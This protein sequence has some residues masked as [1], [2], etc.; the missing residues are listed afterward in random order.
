MRWVPF[1][2]MAVLAALVI[3]VPLVR[4]RKP[5]VSRADYDLQVYRDQ[6]R[7]LQEDVERGVVTKEQKAAAR[8]EID[9][10]ILGVTDTPYRRTGELLKWQMAVAL[11]ILVPAVSIGLYWVLGA[12]GA[13][14]QP[15]AD[16]APIIQEAPIS[17]EVLDFIAEQTAMLEINPEDGEGWMLLGRAH[18]Y[19]GDF[20]D[21]V[22]AFRRAIALGLNAAGTQMEMVESLYNIAGGFITQEAQAAIDAALV[23]D[24]AHPGARFYQGLALSQAER[25]QEAFDVWISLAADTPADAPLW[26][27][28][29]QSLQEAAQQLGLNLAELMPP[30]PEAAPQSPLEAMTAEEQMALIEGMVS[31][32][33]ER[34]VEEPDDLEGWLRLSQSY[35]VLGLLDDAQEAVARAVA[36]S[37]NDP[38]VLLQQ[39][40]LMLTASEDGMVPP[41]AA[42]IFRRALELEPDSAEALFYS[43]VAYAE[44]DDPTAARAE[45]T[46]LLALLDPAGDA[47]ARVQ[48]R[49]DAL[50]AE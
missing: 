27:F 8:L 21:S 43:G 9:R 38:L 37:P 24:P 14:D 3:A 49:M 39:A 13:D 30:P 28:L 44:T 42:V 15:F 50:S 40:G 41:E 47:Y 10:R 5:P 20:E 17:Q 35:R 26:P 4:N 46:K 45:W 25:T 6:L 34:L 12:P 1:I 11:G 16:R 32:L 22:S 23:D 31:Q 48:I 36:L 29:R 7:E 2:I 18:A 33:A 19:T